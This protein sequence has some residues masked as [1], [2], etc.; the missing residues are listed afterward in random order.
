[1][2]SLAFPGSTG[3]EASK[4]FICY[5]LLVPRMSLAYWTAAVVALTGAEPLTPREMQKKMGIGINLG[6]TLDAP[7]E[8]AWAPAA[9]ESFFVEYKQK[10]FTNVRIP[11]QW[12]H[13][14]EENAPYRVNATFMDRVEQIVDWSL[15]RGFVT[16]LNTH[17]DEWLEN[18]F[19]AQLPRFE[20]LWTQIAER[21]Q[22]KDETLLFEVY[23]EPHASGFTVDDLNAMNAAALRIIRES[24]PT[25]IVL[26]G[27]LQYMNPSW[28]VSNPHAMVF[29]ANDT[30]LMLEIHNY[31]PYHYAGAPSAITSHS[32]GSDADRAALTQW[33]DQ[34]GNWSENKG[35]PIYYGE[36]GCT[37]SQTAETGRY[38]WYDAHRAEIEARGWAAAVWDDDGYYGVF[39]RNADKWDEQLLKALGKN[40][41]A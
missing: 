22:G 38:V 20:A 33:C 36:F 34:I 24:N 21:F 16:V 23:N 7:E 17:H 29:P 32:W 6:N 37:N 2:I 27:G 40:A 13:H 35:V 11:T 39:D 4:G 31:D 5:K 14:I 19:E 28:V 12:G 1:M 18:D 10:G 25:R 15:G 26:F 30:Q 9:K 3:R 41:V 8:G